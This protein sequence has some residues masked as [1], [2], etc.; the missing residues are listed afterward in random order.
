MVQYSPQPHEAVV[1]LELK[2]TKLLSTE[3]LSA[4]E[5]G[6]NTYPVEGKDVFDL[7]TGVERSLPKALFE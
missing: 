6:E 4:E 5:P 1:D 2:L 7:K 3:D